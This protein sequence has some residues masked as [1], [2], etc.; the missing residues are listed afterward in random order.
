MLPNPD[1]AN[2]C[3]RCRALI[4]AGT[5]NPDGRGNPADPRLEKLDSLFAAVAGRGGFHGALGVVYKGG[6]FYQHC[7]GLAN[8]ETGRAFTPRTSMEI[9]SLSKQFTAA[10]I[11]LLEQEGVLSSEDC[12]ASYLPEGFPYKEVK[13][14]H[15]VTHTAGLPDYTPWFIE[16]WK[17]DRFVTNADIMAYLIEHRPDA[18]FAPGERY[19]YS[20]TGYV[21]LAEVVHQASGMP[22]DVF[23]QDRLFD[24]FPFEHSGFYNRSLI[25]E[26][27]NYAPSWHWSADEG[28]YV[29]PES[30]PG[31]EYLA[32]LSGRLGPGRLSMSL[33][34]LYLWNYILDTD[35]VLSP[36]SRQK[37][38]SPADVGS[39]D[40]TYGFG[41]HNLL[42]SLAGRVSYH[43]GS[44]A[45]NLSYI[46][47]YHDADLT[48]IALNNARQSELMREI[49][50]AVEQIMLSHVLEQAADTRTSVTGTAGTAGD[51]D[52]P[53]GLPDIAWHMWHNPQSPYF[54]KPSLRQGPCQALPVGVFDSGTGGLTVL[55][56][57]MAFDAH[58]NQT[59]AS[60]PDGIPDLAGEQFI[61]LADQANMPYGL[62]ASE[63]N[64]PLL[65]EH[66]FKNLHFLLS[67]QYYS[68]AENALPES[69]DSPV[70]AVVIACNTATAFG[71]DALESFMEHTG[72]DVPVFG[73]IDAGVRGA[74]EAFLP[75]DSGSV[76]VLATVGTVQSG[77]Y[78]SALHR[79][80]EASGRSGKLMVF[81]QGGHGM[82]EAID[83]EPEFIDR[84]AQQPRP[85]YR[86][87]SMGLGPGSENPLGYQISP[88]LL[89]AYNFN[90]NENNLLTASSDAGP[91]MQLN[92]PE[93]YMRYH[94]VSL[95]E[96]MR[97]NPGALPMKALILGCTHYPYL[98]AEIR[99]ILDELYN[100][101]RNGQYVYRH[102]LDQDIAIV[103]PAEHLAGELFH[104]LHT[105]E[106]MRANGES[107]DR[108]Y[109][110]VPNPFVGGSDATANGRFTYE[111]KYGR[112]AGDML[113]Y[114]RVVP[115]GPDH[116]PQET[117]MRLE[118]FTPQVF[119]SVLLFNPA[120]NPKQSF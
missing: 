86:G 95:L 118:K 104:W 91:L 33:E 98:D 60:G 82:A 114:V 85:A 79:I 61:Y 23:L 37:M 52:W 54:L 43:T 21:V 8:M 38:F 66:I 105:H 40:M 57:L 120:L 41:Y 83:G 3:E 96:Q 12:A 53:D 2:G 55:E 1:E 20:N 73:V 16:N 103:D 30:I 62:Y 64:T 90:L 115:F 74:L 47:K 116:I 18:V 27:E 28:R 19:A 29:R 75:G 24:R 63:E 87:P 78:E 42:D 11:L 4:H 35:A 36:A 68:R 51:R 56:A 81:S 48:V 9:A 22:L 92:H 10:A 107:A 49:R 76:G 65:E 58:S 50:E 34:D 106:M 88:D 39:L 7:S 31:R 67:G 94:L 102:L 97:Q 84:K 6:V 93:N 71:L 45:S 119:R 77:G 89:D 46:K 108:Y 17:H 99:T 59:F 72:L 111:Y 25:Y 117:L 109:I 113:E 112:R 44:W 26:M 80:W 32:F 15:L 69:P 110:S 100:F 5:N 13:I 101:S 70:K 14:I